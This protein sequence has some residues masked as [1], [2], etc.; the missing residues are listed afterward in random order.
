MDLFESQRDG[1]A[2]VEATPR[3]IEGCVTYLGQL[4]LEPLLGKG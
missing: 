1:E 3:A 2:A 4:L